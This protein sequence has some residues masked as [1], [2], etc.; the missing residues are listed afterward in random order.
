VS[1]FD[2]LSS[3]EMTVDRH[4]LLQILLNLFTNAAH[5]MR[6]R[7]SERRLAVRVYTDGDRVVFEVKDNGVGISTENLTRIFAHGFT[8]KSDGHGFGLHSC[9]NAAREMG[10]RLRA[11][12]EGPG[13]GATFTLTLPRVAATS[14]SPPEA[15][16]A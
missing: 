6:P 16:S 13:L 5:A 7:S 8:T 1:H 11:S 3:D 14:A 15:A 2:G 12:S 9:A 10:G 4:K